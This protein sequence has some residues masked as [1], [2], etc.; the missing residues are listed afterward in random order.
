MLLPRDLALF[1]CN[2]RGVY[3]S[4]AR[5]DHHD[6]KRLCNLVH[7]RDGTCTTTHRNPFGGV[8]KEA[9][10]RS[11]HLFTEYELRRAR[12]GVSFTGLITQPGKT[13][14]IRQNER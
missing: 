9:T 11:S 14:C 5:A 1:A 2:V 7:P 4:R 13:C 3:L 6:Q 12:G 8:R 10:P